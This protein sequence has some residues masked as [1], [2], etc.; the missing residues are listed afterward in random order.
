MTRAIE[1]NKVKVHSGVGKEECYLI[2]RMIEGHL[3]KDVGQILNVF[4]D[5][6]DSF[7]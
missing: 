5:K 7:C 4:E 3:K 6:A 1:K 2:A